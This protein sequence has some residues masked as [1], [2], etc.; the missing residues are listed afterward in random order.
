MWNQNQDDTQNFWLV[1]L[2]LLVHTIL[3]FIQKPPNPL[4][5][6]E[7]PSFYCARLGRNSPNNFKSWFHV[8][9]KSFLASGSNCKVVLGGFIRDRSLT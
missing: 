4:V 1:R 2:D 7:I 8:Y 5:Y 3:S 9:L 6:T